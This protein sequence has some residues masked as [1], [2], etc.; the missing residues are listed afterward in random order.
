MVMSLALA[1]LAWKFDHLQL[2]VGQGEPSLEDY[3]VPKR[4]PLEVDL[5]ASTM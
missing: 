3:F 4:G 5:G 2:G 1:R